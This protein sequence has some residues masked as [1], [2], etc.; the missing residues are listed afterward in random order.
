MPFRRH[1]RKIGAI[2]EAADDALTLNAGTIR[3]LA[4]VDANL[5]LAQHTITA[6]RGH[7]VD[8]SL[9]VAPR[10]T[11]TGISSRPQNGTAYGAGEWIRIWVGFDRQIEVSGTPQPVSYTHLTL[12]TTPYV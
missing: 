8:G 12:P 10:V 7:N 5:D 9:V 1:W 3:S 2:R 6:A 4:G 11:R